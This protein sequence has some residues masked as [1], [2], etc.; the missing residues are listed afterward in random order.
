MKI[1]C[2]GSAPS[3]VRTGPFLDASWTDYQ[4]GIT[5]AYPPSQFAGEVWQIWGCSPGLFGFATRA[6]RWFELHRWEPGA[7]WFSPQYVQ[8][9]REFK[10]PV[11]TG[12]V[13]EEIPNHVVY[14]LP[15][16]E[17]NFS[18]FF[19][20]SSLSLMAGLAILEIEQIRRARRGQD[21]LPAYCNADEMG[22]TD[23]DDVIGFFGVDMSALEEYA[24]QKPGCWFFILEALRRGIGVIYPPESDLGC[25]EP[26][27][28]ICEWD[29]Q[30]IKA[31]ARMREINQR[32]SQNG[33]TIQQLTAQTHADMGAKDDLHY[34]IKTWCSPY[35]LEAGT[36][37]R[38]IPGT[39]LGVTTAHA[40]STPQPGVM[41]PYVGRVAD[42]SS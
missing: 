36:V 17:A 10:G 33:A 2:M 29:H 24:R 1:A 4:A 13:I 9:L 27:Y 22:K 42:G 21:S 18:A 30:Y 8:F 38:H 35:R 6:N 28:G 31:T 37:M 16:I 5:Q 15:L 20:N 11:Y 7:E 23:T 12:G 19:L 26:V 32:L 39:G 34:Q 14:P 41:S 3:S 25:P 40:T